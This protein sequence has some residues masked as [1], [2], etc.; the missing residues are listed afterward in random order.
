MGT[1]HCC[2]VAGTDSKTKENPPEELLEETVQAGSP[3]VM[4]PPMVAD[5]RGLHVSS[6]QAVEECRLPGRVVGQSERSV[7]A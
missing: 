7:R 5:V 6:D 3:G 2:W 1:M 4:D